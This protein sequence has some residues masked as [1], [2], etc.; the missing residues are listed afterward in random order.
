MPLRMPCA[1]PDLWSAY[2]R[3][4]IGM[5]DAS[6]I[7]HEGDLARPGRMAGRMMPLERGPYDLII[8]ANC[9][10]ELFGTNRIAL[11][12]RDPV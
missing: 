4:A 12:E 8:V 11:K 2:E 1:R 6:L 7:L 9:L 3:Q 5:G 10:N